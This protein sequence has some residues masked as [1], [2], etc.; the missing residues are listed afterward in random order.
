MNLFILYKT[1]FISDLFI[2]SFIHMQVDEE[3]EYIV[4]TS[5]IIPTLHFEKWRITEHYAWD[6][7]LSI[8]CLI[9][10]YVNSI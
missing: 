5:L 3:M 10:H 1:N 8:N 2:F 9:L 6:F 4:L 7:D